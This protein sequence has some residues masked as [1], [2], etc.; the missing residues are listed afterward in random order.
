MRGGLIASVYAPSRR[1]EAG[2]TW[3]AHDGRWYSPEGWV[4]RLSDSGIHVTPELAMS[5]SAIWAGVTFMARNLSSLPCI[6]YERTS[7]HG[8]DGR[9]RATDHRLHRR[10]RWRPNRWHNALEFW[11]MA[12]GHILLRGNS[13][14]RLIEGPTGFADEVRPI[15]PDR[16]R[17]ARQPSGRITY[18]VVDLEGRREVLSEDEIFHIRGFMSDGVVVAGGG[19]AVAGRGRR[20][21]H[22]GRAV[23]QDRDDGGPVGV[24]AGRAGRRE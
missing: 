9:R 6:L 24:G 8:R 22:H 7:V 12:I 5:L 16:V 13:I 20:G 23:L 10:L 18:T 14:S 2:G 4:T 21:G 1:A 15:H 17:V 11:E 3:A 19:G